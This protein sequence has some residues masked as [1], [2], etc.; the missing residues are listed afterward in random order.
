MWH[1]GQNNFFDLYIPNSLGCR[2]LVPVRVVP[3]R[4]DRQGLAPPVQQLPHFLHTRR[5]EFKPLARVL[6]GTGPQMGYDRG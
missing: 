6:L 5:P 3:A 1:I 4:G 2:L